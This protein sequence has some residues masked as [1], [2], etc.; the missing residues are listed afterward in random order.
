MAVY[1]HAARSNN[2]IWWGG[3]WIHIVLTETEVSLFTYQTKSF[4]T[5]EEFDD[6]PVDLLVT[7][8]TK[9]CCCKAICCYPGQSVLLGS[10]SW[11]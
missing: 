2:I 3:Q 9:P 8:D 10:E 6:V 5:V 7:F 1:S 11:Y 4:K